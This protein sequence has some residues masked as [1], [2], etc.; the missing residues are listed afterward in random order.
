MVEGQDVAVDTGAE[1][2]VNDGKVNMAGAGADTAED[3]STKGTAGLD[4][5]GKDVK[6]STKDAASDVDQDD[7]VIDD[8]KPIPYERFKKVIEQKNAS[9]TES[10]SLRVENEGMAELLNNPLVFR[11]VLQGKGITDPKILAEKMREA[12]FE[13][14]EKTDQTEDELFNEFSKGLDLNSPKDW[15]KMMKKMSEYYAQESVKPVMGKLSNREVQEWISSQE[16]QA[17]KIAKEVYNLEY[18]VSG[19]DESNPNT[20]IGK[21]WKYLEKH[22]EHARLGH[23][24]LIH[25]ALA[26]EGAKLGEQA[27]IKK[28]KQ[29][30]IDLK[31]SAMEDDAQAAREGSP[32]ANWSVPE[33]MAWRRKHGK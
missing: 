14:D 22:P 12:G 33:L 15:F 3:S 9:K 27:G 10:E 4:E 16:T 13:L 11:A 6:T 32:D 2:I 21:I 29:R 30:Q 19:K 7:K 28:E 8:G 18:G 5:S 25:L 23:A 24:T 1:E 17:Q 31:S 26:P 20:A